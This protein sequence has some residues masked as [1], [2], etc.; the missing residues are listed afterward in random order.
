MAAFG[1]S[2]ADVV[3]GGYPLGAAGS[4]KEESSDSLQHLWLV[5]VTCAAVGNVLVNFGINLM[6]LAHKN[7]ALTLAK[8]EQQPS[9]VACM[10]VWQVGLGTFV[11]GTSVN[12]I[13][14]GL[15]AQSLVAGMN[16]VQ[17]VSNVVFAKYI[18]GEKV[19]KR[20]L[21]ATALIVVG[22]LML[23]LYGDHAS[24]SYT[25][26]ELKSLYTHPEYIAFLSAAVGSAGLAHLTYCYF[27]R[28]IFHRGVDN[29]HW[30]KRKALPF[31]YAIASAALGAQSVLF[32]KC[33]STMLRTTIGGKPQL[34]AWFLYVFLVCQ[35]TTQAYWLTRLNKGLFQFDALTIVPTMQICWCVF[36]VSEGLVYF[37]EYKAF[38]QYQW[39]TFWVAFLIILAGVYLLSP[40]IK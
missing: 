36:S 31:L 22:N 29:V 2:A 5:G 7:R 40:R 32:A 27:K 37:Q 16:S 20:V 6:K 10:T 8:G 19:T 33:V 23:I 26:D 30:T 1:G 15:A 18:L 25:A 21:V 4:S 39:V 11:T 13:A 34:G 17:F 9:S 24:K 28:Q 35:F 14:L 12:F 3:A 38:N